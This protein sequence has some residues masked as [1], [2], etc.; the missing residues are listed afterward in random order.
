MPPVNL[1]GLKKTEGGMSVLWGDVIT[2]AAYTGHLERQDVAAEELAP[3]ESVYEFKNVTQEE[4]KLPDELRPGVYRLTIAATA[5]GWQAS[6]SVK[7]QFVIKPKQ[8]DLA[9]IE[10]EMNSS[11][12]FTKIS[13]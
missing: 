11:Y 13:N 1:T 10:S 5:K 4:L 12:D 2:G 9:S 7:K 8:R 3:W 6:P